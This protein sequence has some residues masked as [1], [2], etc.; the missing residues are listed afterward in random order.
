[1][2]VSLTNN[3]DLRYFLPAQKRQTRQRC[4]EQSVCGRFWHWISDELQPVHGITYRPERLEAGAQWVAKQVERGGK[5]IILV[6]EACRIPNV[7][8]ELIASLPVLIGFAIAQSGPQNLGFEHGQPGASPQGWVVPT[9]GYAAKLTS[10]KP[11]AGVL[12]AEIVRRPLHGSRPSRASPNRRLLLPQ[13]RAPRAS[14]ILSAPR[15]ALTARPRVGALQGAEV[16]K[17]WSGL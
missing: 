10:E 2:P 1:M 15:V 9:P 8:R 5:G 13:L 7:R 12:C 11:K 6:P 17:S 3:Y 16:R 14:C 4:A